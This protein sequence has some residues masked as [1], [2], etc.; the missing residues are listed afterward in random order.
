MLGTWGYIIWGLL[1]IKLVFYAA[2]LWRQNFRLGV[3]GVAAVMI[4]ALAV[5]VLGSFYPGGIP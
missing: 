1:S 2:W 4:A 3:L 5:L